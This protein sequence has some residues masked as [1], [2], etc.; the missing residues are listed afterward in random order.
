MPIQFTQSLLVL[1]VRR[2]VHQAKVTMVQI[3]YSAGTQ[4]LP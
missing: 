4:Q 3:H 1:A 2:K